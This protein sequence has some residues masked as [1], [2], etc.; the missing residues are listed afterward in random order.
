MCTYDIDLETLVGGIRAA[1]PGMTLVGSTSFGEMSSVLGFQEDSVVL[2]VFASDRVDITTGCGAGVSVSSAQAARDALDQARAGTTQ[3]PRLCLVV[4][5]ISGDDPAALLGALQDLLGDDVPVIGGGSAPRTPPDDPRIA[6]QFH[7]DEILQ[8]SA[9]VLLF[10]G[11]VAFSFGIDTGWQPIG[12]RGRVT[13]TSGSVV[14]T[15]DDQPAVAFYQRYLGAE[16]MPSAA[17]PLA[18]FEGE[19]DDF[20]LRVALKADPTDGSLSMA[21][22]IPLGAVVQL[23]VAVTEE[24]FAG[25]RSAVQKAVKRFPVASTATAALV[26]SCA[27]RRLVLGTRTGT[28]LDITRTELGDIPIGG[29]YCYGEIAPIETGASRFHNETLVAVLLGESVS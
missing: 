6:R 8:D 14:Q 16:A 15:I 1:Y 7:D 9:A 11:P 26:F 22:S 29:F 2:A 4:P 10:S 13:G 3:P 25:A 19:T 12:G 27:I 5:C 18:V 28:E 24:I 23:T 21:G 17:N 20:Y